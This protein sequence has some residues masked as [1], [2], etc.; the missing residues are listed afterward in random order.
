MTSNLED[1]L[2]AIEARNR[3]V[4]LDKTWETSLY[5]RVLIL[6]ITY[7]LLGIYMTFLGVRLPWSNAV[8][9]TTGF[10]LSTLTLNWAK[11]RWLEKQ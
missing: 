8:I 10:L 3:R 1:R 9:P 11:R 2:E 5:R 4:D 6:V 7:V